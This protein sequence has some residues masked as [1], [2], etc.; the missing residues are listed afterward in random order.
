MKKL[1]FLFLIKLS[2]I[3]PQNN[4]LS[5]TFQSVFENSNYVLSGEV[6]EKNSYWDINKSKIYTV[7]KLRSHVFYKGE[8]SEFLYFIT[9]GGAVGLEGMISSKKIRINRN[10]KGYFQ[11][12]DSPDIRLDGFD[13]SMNLYVLTDR[14]YGFIEYDDYT[15]SIDFRDNGLISVNDFENILLSFSKKKTKTND[16]YFFGSQNSNLIS[17]ATQITD[18]YPT[19]IGAGNKE[20][21]TISGNGFGSYETSSARAKVFFSD[22]DS[23]GSSWLECLNSQ[24]ISWSNDEIQVQVPSG[25]GTGPVRIQKVDGFYFQSDQIINIP[26]NIQA[27]VYPNDGTDDDVEYP[28]YHTGSVVDDLGAELDNPGSQEPQ[29]HISGGKFNLTLNQ[30]FFDNTP[31]KDTFLAELEDWTCNTGINFTVNDETTPTAT[32]SRDAMN[33]VTFD[34]SQSLGTTYWYFNGCIQRNNITNEIVDLTVYF[35]EIDIVFNSNINWGYG[36]VVSAGEYDFSSTAL[37]ELGHAV[38]LGHVINPTGLMH[39]AGGTGQDNTGVIDD[40][41]DAL[42]IILRRNISTP[43]CDVLDPHEVS[44]CSSIDVNQDSDGDGINDVFDDCPNT[45][46]NE[47]VDSK[48]CGLS[49]RD[50]DNDGLFDNVDSCPNTPPN[51][52]VD[53]S[54]CADTDSDGVFDSFDLCPDTPSGAEIDSDGCA[55]FQR[56]SDGDGVTDDFDQCP[57]TPEGESVDAYGCYTFLLNYDNFEIVG[58]SSVCY[59]TQD[60]SIDISVNNR[61][62]QYQVSINGIKYQLNDQNGYDLLISDLDVG[63][64]EVCFTVIGN[65]N[66]EQCFLVVLN[67]P[68]Q[69][70]VIDS[71][72]YDGEFV[73]FELVGSDSF[74]VTHNGLEKIYNSN[75]FVIPLQKGINNIIISTDLECQGFFE[76]N[77]FNS[78]KIYISPNP[79]KDNINIFIS[80]KDEQAR[81]TIRNLSGSVLYDEIKGIN[82][83]RTLNIN[84]ED[85]STGLYFIEITGKTIKQYSKIIK[86]E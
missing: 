20:I 51:A 31:A 16:S 42:S 75:S 37:H 17:G 74:N 79:T 61:E 68:E 63:N 82:G 65:N 8:T 80:G 47:E 6:I 55:I 29:D 19:S 85:F 48:G 40:Y 57:N 36:E 62:L 24:I 12:Q 60:G 38:G 27:L 49:Q 35:D 15:K 50:S 9:E 28:I 32:N 44:E 30:D 56:D 76:K 86:N 4:N 52:V 73:D 45:P 69:L 25:S 2:V 84:L 1:L 81:L 26:Y 14:I 77:Y 64:Y 23:G 34:S 72:S 43:V 46:E 18:L 10:S 11:L 58:T 78:E 5:D 53:S 54:G 39:Y 66:F 13:S 41:L 7:H 67:Q 3:Y 21:L 22:S 70:E 33:V 83:E 59:G 71:L